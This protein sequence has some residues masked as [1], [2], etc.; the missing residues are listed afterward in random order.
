[1]PNGNTELVDL[2][3][4]KFHIEK[5]DVLEKFIIHNFSIFFAKSFY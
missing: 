1:M 4:S 5:K 3:C 2:D